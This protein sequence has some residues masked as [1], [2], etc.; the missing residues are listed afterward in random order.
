MVGGL[1]AIFYVPI[2]IGNVIIP[3]DFHIFQRGSNHQPEN[4]VQTHGSEHQRGFGCASL[5]E[6]LL[7]QNGA[8]KDQALQE[9]SRFFF[10]CV[11]SPIKFSDKAFELPYIDPDSS[12]YRNRSNL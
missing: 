8:P 12:R 4:M 3:I 2:N 1:V 11:I 10:V 5:V 7:A 9:M 6:L